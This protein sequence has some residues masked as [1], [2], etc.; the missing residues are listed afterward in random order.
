[1]TRRNTRGL[2]SLLAA[3]SLRVVCELFVRSPA[4]FLAGGQL[5]L[6]AGDKLGLYQETERVGRRLQVKRFFVSFRLHWFSRIL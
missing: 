1:M 4:S 6:V 2:S 5:Q 3:S